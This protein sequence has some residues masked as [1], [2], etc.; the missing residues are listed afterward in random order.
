LNI[1]FIRVDIEVV[2]KLKVSLPKEKAKNQ[3]INP[4]NPLLE[5]ARGR[6]IKK[7]FIV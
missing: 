1:D 5:G 7:L 3:T 6:Y 4:Y 2:L